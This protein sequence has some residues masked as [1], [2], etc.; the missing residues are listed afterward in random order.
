[1]RAVSAFELRDRCADVLSL[2]THSRSLFIGASVVATGQ[3]P[4]LLVERSAGR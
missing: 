4:I 2:L 1:M 3:L